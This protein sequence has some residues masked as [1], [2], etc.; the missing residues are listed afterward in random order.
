MLS[1]DLNEKSQAYYLTCDTNMFT[2]IKDGKFTCKSD[3]WSYGVVLW[4]M[5]TLAEQPYQGWSNDEVNIK[6]INF[7]LYF[8][9]LQ[10]LSDK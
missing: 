10:H 1:K 2:S 6:F 4:E 7:T 8:L 3:V 5:A 9:H